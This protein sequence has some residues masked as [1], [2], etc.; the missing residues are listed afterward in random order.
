MKKLIGIPSA[1]CLTASALLAAPAQAHE[2]DAGYWYLSPALEYI[3]A[4]DDRHADDSFGAQ[5][6]IGRYLS[7]SW[8][9]E[10][11]LEGDNLDLK[12][13][14]GKFQQRGAS[15]DGLFFFDRSTAFSPYGM[16]RP[17]CTASTSVPPSASESP[18]VIVIS[19]RSAGSA[20]S[21]S[22]TSTTRSFG[23]SLTK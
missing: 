3:V 16:V 4:D 22:T 7:R 14:N 21:N 18:I 1:L 12:N 2:D 20:V 11:N 9:L 8:N 6:G 15:L 23:T 17:S 13:S 19:P 10:L 5:L